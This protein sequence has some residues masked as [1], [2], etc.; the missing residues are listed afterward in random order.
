LGNKNPAHAPS[1]VGKK[2]KMADT[3]R[4]DFSKYYCGL[5]KK[6]Q[7][8]YVEKLTVNGAELQD[9]YSESFQGWEKKT[10]NWP[11]VEY[12]DIWQ[13]LIDTPGKHTKSKMKA[14]KSLDGYNFFLSGHVRTCFY[15]PIST[16][17][18]VCFIKAKVTPSQSVNKTPHEVWLCLDKHM[19][20]VVSAHCTCKAG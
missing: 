14:Y 17:S 15:N 18:T 12:G 3:T 13:Y 20:Y 11:T 16:D 7:E 6:S 5:D 19:G 8:R 4:V 10:T 2:V 1:L 9:P